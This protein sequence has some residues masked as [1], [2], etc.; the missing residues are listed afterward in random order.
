MKHFIYVLTLSI[1]CTTLLSCDTDIPETDTTPPTFRIEISGDEFT[2]AFTE[3][4]NFD[5]FQ[6][7]LRSNTTYNIIFSGVDQGGVRRLQM[8]LPD[9]YVDFQTGIEAP[10]QTTV[11]GLTNTIYWNGDPENPITAYIFTGSFVA[12]GDNIGATIYMRAEDFGGEDG[13]PFNI[14]DASLNISI[15]DQN[16]EVVTY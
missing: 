13:P 2:R 5:T 9:D 7:N 16:T 6:L 8:E 10:W 12:S 15:G 1:L 14:T 4:D 11:S 3:E